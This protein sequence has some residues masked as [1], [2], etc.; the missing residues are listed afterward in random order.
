MRLPSVVPPSTKWVEEFESMVLERLQSYVADFLHIIQTLNSPCLRL[1]IRED[2]QPWGWNIGLACISDFSPKRCQPLCASESLGVSSEFDGF[3]LLGVLDLPVGPVLDESSAHNLIVRGSEI[4]QPS[5]LAKA[6]LYRY[7]RN[8]HAD[9]P[10]AAIQFVSE[11]IWQM[12]AILYAHGTC[13]PGMDV[14]NSTW[15]GRQS[16]IIAEVMRQISIQRRPPRKEMTTQQAALWLEGRLEDEKSYMVPRALTGAEVANILARTD[17]EPHYELVVSGARSRLIARICNNWSEKGW[18]ISAKVLPGGCLIG[19]QAPA[20]I[21]VYVRRD[22]TGIEEHYPVCKIGET[23][24]PRVTQFS[25][26]RIYRFPF[27][28]LRPYSSRGQKY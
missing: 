23:P 9:A 8:P 12:S 25:P 13:F 19:K 21:E 10:R 17:I 5:A 6:G 15:T 27:A 1:A 26:S 28:R 20:R 24:K 22:G 2:G 7:A 18:R 11:C 4:V 14:A 16:L 3:R